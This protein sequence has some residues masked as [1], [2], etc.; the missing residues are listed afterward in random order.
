MEL[1]DVFPRQW[2]VYLYNLFSWNYIWKSN[3]YTSK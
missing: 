1:M 2:I 3:K